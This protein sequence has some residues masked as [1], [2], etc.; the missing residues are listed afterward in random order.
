MDNKNE[1]APVCLFT[2]NRLEETK[3]TIKALQNNYLAKESELFVFSDGWKNENQKT[4][5]LEIRVFLKTIK[6]FKEV[7]VFESETNKGL[8]DSIINGVTE[9]INKY[10]KVIVLE[11]DLETTPNFLNFMNDSLNFYKRD[12]N[13]QSVSGY[14]LDIKKDNSDESDVYFQQRTHSWGWA[15]WKSYWGQCNFDLDYLRSYVLNNENKL[16]DFKQTCGADIDR[17]LLD[18]IY[19]R[20]NSWYVRWAFNQFLNNRYTV[21]PFLSK[22]NNI[23][24][25]DDA[26]HCTSINVYKTKMDI[27]V[28]TNFNFLSFKKNNYYQRQFLYYFSI[29]YKLIYRALLLKTSTGRKSLMID[30][31]NKLKINSRKIAQIITGT[32]NKIKI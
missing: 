14:S 2:F 3:K 28:K 25:G 13:I 5:I 16:K 27:L 19:S 15:T 24:F 18:T 7:T 20:N 31:N 4:K 26:T 12:E 9:I 32:R 29:I 21:Y 1:L 8:A 11:D 30:F 6:G 22:I 10:G 17:M 23:G